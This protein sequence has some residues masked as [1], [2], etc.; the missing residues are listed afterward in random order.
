MIIHVLKNYKWIPI[1][2]Q[3]YTLCWTWHIL[4]PILALTQINIL[5]ILEWTLWWY[6]IKKKRKLNIYWKKI[7]HSLGQQ[8]P[9]WWNNCVY[10]MPDILD[11]N[12]FPNLR[13]C[14]LLCAKVFKP[15]VLFWL[16]KMM[17]FLLPDCKNKSLCKNISEHN[18]SFVHRLP[19]D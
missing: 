1:M 3:I 15:S 2:Y 19:F 6:A 16:Q 10:S 14:I 5:H 11:S 12:S 8:R 13:Y 4:H 18:I 7:Q 17:R 9:P